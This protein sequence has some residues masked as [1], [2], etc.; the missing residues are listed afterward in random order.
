MKIAQTIVIAYWMTRLFINILNHG[1]FIKKPVLKYNAFTVITDIAISAT[2][3]YWGGFFDS[4][5]K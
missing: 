2:V 5:L 4:L 1:E 3:L